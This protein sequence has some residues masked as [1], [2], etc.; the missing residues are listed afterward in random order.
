MNHELIT[1]EADNSGFCVVCGLALDECPKHGPADR[2]GSKILDAHDRGDHVGCNPKG[3]PLAGTVTGRAAAG[4]APTIVT[5]DAPV[6]D[7]VP[8]WATRVTAADLRGESAPVAPAPAA[9]APVEPVVE[10]EPV[11]SGGIVWEEPEEPSRYTWLATVASLKE[12]PGEWAKVLVAPDR[13]EA[14]RARNA[15]RYHGAE[16]K[17]KK[18]GDTEVTVWAKWPTDAKETS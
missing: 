14:N 12:R 10:S 18:T 2:A 17:T 16:T 6:T 5:H 7:D 8:R 13:K 3:C 1:A 9:P 4:W 15:L 11:E